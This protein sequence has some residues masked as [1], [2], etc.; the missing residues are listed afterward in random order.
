MS[1]EVHITVGGGD[2]IEIN[3][4][5]AQDIFCT[6]MVNM[7]AEEYGYTWKE[8]AGPSS[9]CSKSFGLLGGV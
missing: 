7:V 8:V 6:S 4:G 9:A 1:I 5:G 3:T 2:D